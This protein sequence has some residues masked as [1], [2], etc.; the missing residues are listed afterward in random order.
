MQVRQLH[1]FDEVLKAVRADSSS[2]YLQPLMVDA[3]LEPDQ[4]P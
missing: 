2:Q 4:E 3:C 1:Q